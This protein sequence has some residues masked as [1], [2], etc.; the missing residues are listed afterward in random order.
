M[1]LQRDNF[2]EGQ[3][4]LPILRR[5]MQKKC[6]LHILICAFLSPEGSPRAVPDAVELLVE[7]PLLQE[8][9]LVLDEQFHAFDRGR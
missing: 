5:K 4:A 1:I 3:K 9:V 6:K 2:T 7:L 8:L